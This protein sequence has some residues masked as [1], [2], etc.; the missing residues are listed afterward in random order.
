MI[1]ILT[2]DKEYVCD[3]DTQGQAERVIER[4]IRQKQENGG[5]YDYGV[6][7]FYIVGMEDGQPLE[8][9]RYEV[10]VYCSHIKPDGLHTPQIKKY[11]VLC[12]T[13]KDGL[14]TA[15][16]LADDKKG[17][18]MTTLVDRYTGDIIY[19]KIEVNRMGNGMW[20]YD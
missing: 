19:Q 5:I 4:Y 12:R 10:E 15:R 7:N 20:Y 3:V 13:I 6:E 2:P 17:L 8:E 18:Y 11:G 14:R 9:P 1:R 16:R